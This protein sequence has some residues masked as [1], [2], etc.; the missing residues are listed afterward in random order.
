MSRKKIEMR[1]IVAGIE[2]TPIQII[3]KSASI[4]PK[5][6]IQIMFTKKP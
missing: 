3:N 1:Q 2:I 6:C 4:L 5:T